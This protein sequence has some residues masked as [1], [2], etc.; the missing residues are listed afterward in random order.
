[1]QRQVDVGSCGVAQRPQAPSLVRP[2]SSVQTVSWLPPLTRWPVLGDE[3]PIRSLKAQL[4][5]VTGISLPAS[6]RSGGRARGREGV[7]RRVQE[8]QGLR[9]RE[10]HRTWTGNSGSCILTGG[11]NFPL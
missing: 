1:M 11:S 3:A 5:G 2:L 7:F 10:K 6:G 4:S 8:A 9:D